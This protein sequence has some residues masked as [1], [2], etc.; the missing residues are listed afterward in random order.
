MGD[1]IGSAYTGAGMK[2]KRLGLVAVSG[3]RFRRPMLAKPS[4]PRA[5]QVQTPKAANKPRRDDNEQEQTKSTAEPG[6]PLAAV[7]IVP[8]AAKE[9]NQ[10]KD[11]QNCAHNPASRRIFVVS[12]EPKA[13]ITFSRRPAPRR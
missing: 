6:A 11:D 5:R 4:K 2:S 12:A 7:S 1:A 10:N 13:S 9:K 8:T 3:V